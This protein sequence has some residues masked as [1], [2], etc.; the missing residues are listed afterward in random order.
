MPGRNDRTLVWKFPQYPVI[1]ALVN[2]HHQLI[3]DKPAGAPFINESVQQMGKIAGIL[4][5]VYAHALRR[6]YARDIAHLPKD[7]DG[8]TTTG[9]RESLDHNLNFA[10]AVTSPYI[11]GISNEFNSLRASNKE[12]IHRREPKFADIQALTPDEHATLRPRKHRRYSNTELKDFFKK[13]WPLGIKNVTDFDDLPKQSQQ[14]V[15]NRLRDVQ[16][17]ALLENIDVEKPA[18][19]KAN[20]FRQPLMPL[21][22]NAMKQVKESIQARVT[23]SMSAVHLSKERACGETLFDLT[24][25][26]WLTR[27]LHRT[28]LRVRSQ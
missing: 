21:D 15:R 6:G 28:M 14:Y 7:F 18:T 10:P 25:A 16:D 24:P 8:T 11:G 12:K 19:K 27:T 2:G 23:V 13:Q 4:S 22:G 3:L 20:R 1:C 26:S 5:A 17:K 9:V